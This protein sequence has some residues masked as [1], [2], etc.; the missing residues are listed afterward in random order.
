MQT[1]FCDGF[2]CQKMKKLWREIFS[3][4][5]VFLV[6]VAQPPHN[7]DILSSKLDQSWGTSGP[8]VVPLCI[9]TKYTASEQ[10]V[11]CAGVLLLVLRRPD[12][13]TVTSEPG[14]WQPSQVFLGELQVRG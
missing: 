12:D 14:H 3:N 13:Y 7:T 6:R 8:P 10:T 1:N 2:G 11:N 5:Q 4:E 9:K